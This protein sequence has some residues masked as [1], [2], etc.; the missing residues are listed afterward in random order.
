LCFQDNM[1]DDWLLPTYELEEE[2][3][4]IP[5]GT[6]PTEFLHIG[7]SEKRKIPVVVRVKY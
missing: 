3:V 4:S 2:L 7:Y 5:I 6:H 1:V